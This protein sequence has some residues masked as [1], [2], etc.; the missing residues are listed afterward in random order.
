MTV[1][2]NVRHEKA[3]VY[4]GRPS[5][6]GNPYFVGKDGTRMDVIFL[7]IDY[8][9]N[10]LQHDPHFKKKIHELKDKKIGCW[11]HPE[12]C[13]LH[14]IAEYLNNYGPTKISE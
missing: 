10:R 13:H 11:C 14:V 1:V 3:D 2:V 12:P 9:F 4:C 6:Y 5:I 7:Y 8:F